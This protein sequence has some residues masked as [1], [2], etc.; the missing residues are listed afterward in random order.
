MKL[1]LFFGFTSSGEVLPKQYVRE[2]RHCYQRKDSGYKESYLM[3]CMK[4]FLIYKAFVKTQEGYFIF[5]D[6]VKFVQYPFVRR[7][8]MSFE[9]VAENVA[10]MT[11]TEK[12]DLLSLVVDSLK[13]IS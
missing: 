8:K 3:E 1:S 10:T 6:T 11:E 7:R 4:C 9:A 13:K 2:L 12:F 5:L